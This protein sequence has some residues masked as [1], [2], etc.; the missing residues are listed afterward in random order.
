M[1]ITLPSLARDGVRAIFQLASHWGEGAIS[2]RPSRRAG[3]LTSM[4][5]TTA[6]V[7]MQRSGLVRSVQDG[8]EATN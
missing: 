3:S 2:L 7:Y 8:W 5:W 4:S 1:A 6:L